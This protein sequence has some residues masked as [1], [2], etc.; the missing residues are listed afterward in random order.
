MSNVDYPPV[1]GYKC[2]AAWT[3][4]TVEAEEQWKCT[5]CKATTTLDA[6]QSVTKPDMECVY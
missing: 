1:T 6:L 2:N 4:C 5:R 3:G